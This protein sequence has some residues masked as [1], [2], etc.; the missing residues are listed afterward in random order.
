MSYG[1]GGKGLAVCIIA[2]VSLGSF[3]I[4]T[5]VWWNPFP[6]DN[7]GTTTTGAS[8]YVDYSFS[9]YAL[10]PPDSITLD[11]YLNS[12]GVTVEFADDPSLLYSIDI[13]VR[14]DTVLEEG[15]PAVLYLN[16]VVSLVYQSGDITVTLGSSIVYFFE[17]HVN[18]GLASIALNEHSNVG[19]TFLG[20]NSG[21][22][23]LALGN[24]CTIFENCTFDL[25]VNSGELDVDI[26][27][28]TAIGCDFYGMVN[29][30]ISDIATATWNEM[31][32]G[33]YQ[34]PSFAFAIQ[35]ITIL[36]AVNSGSLDASLF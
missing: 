17:F 7:G 13:T 24:E 3:F 1:E 35:T 18:S 29:S 15:P 23:S 36:A 14:N 9:N 33:H 28:P 25:F 30:G 16:S 12:G 19:N 31:P 5:L 6:L 26:A 22:L 20:V 34:T 4:G 32:N 21:L 8:E 10:E 2:V 27:V 11:F